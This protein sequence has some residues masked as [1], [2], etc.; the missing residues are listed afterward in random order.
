MRLDCPCWRRRLDSASGDWRAGSQSAACCFAHLAAAAE[1]KDD[2]DCS[3][4][5]TPHCCSIASANS[6]SSRHRAALATLCFCIAHSRR[7]PLSRRCF[8]AARIA[9]PTR[10]A[11]SPSDG[12]TA[13]RGAQKLVQSP[14]PVALLRCVDVAHD[15]TRVIEKSRSSRS[16][17]VTRTQRDQPTRL[18]GGNNT[19][20]HS[21]G[22]IPPHR[23]AAQPRSDRRNRPHAF[24][25]LFASSVLVASFP[26]SSSAAFSSPGS[27]AA[28]RLSADRRGCCSSVLL[29]VRC[30]PFVGVR[31]A[32]RDALYGM[33]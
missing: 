28:V 7:S 16:N 32:Y 1:C 11:A 20:R 31:S 3:N 21:A 27:F 12:R 23:A 17:E 19:A 30:S 18:R 24:L 4:H 10:L 15:T 14:H 33:R 8:P 25:C 26:P 22:P 6:A 9:Q 13:P 5:H 2:G 29:S